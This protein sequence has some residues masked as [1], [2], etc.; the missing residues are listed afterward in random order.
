MNILF[1]LGHPAHF[2][3]NKITIKNLIE[4]G[5]QVT[6][7]INDK[8]ILENLL[9]ESKLSYIKIV[10]KK[11]N[12]SKFGTFLRLLKQ[13]KNLF[14]ISYKK[15]IE[16]LVGSTSVISHVGVLL[17][18]PSIALVED[19][20]EA[21]PPFPQITYPFIS[22]IIAPQECSV[23]RWSHKKIGINSYHELAYLHPNTFKPSFKKIEKYVDSKNDY[24]IIRFSELGAYHDNGISGISDNI[25]KLIIDKLI[26]HGNVYITSERKL[27]CEFEKYRVKINPTDMH[28]FMAFSSIV[29]G[30]SQTM[31]A[32]AA[33]LGVPFIRYNDFVGK[34]S[35]CNSLEEIYNLG[36]GIKAGE[37]KLLLDKVDQLINMSNKN[38]IFNKRKEKMLSEKIDYSLFLLDFI[39]KNYLK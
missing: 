27:N 37:I 1:H 4:Q 35:Y 36:Y 19:D 13:I 25:A 16:L 17:N 22:K 10:G 20:A 23:G 30:D 31:S 5:N 6:I 12:Q 29:I 15:R 26:P 9:I 3:L 18:I 32:E 14:Q 38:E 33:V 24:F 2:H 28:H 8:D 34:L 7:A 21:V 11:N 39:K